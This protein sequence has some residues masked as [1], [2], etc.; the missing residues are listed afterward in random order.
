ML[1]T[2]T[3]K[4]ENHI[5][6]SYSCFDRV[7][8]RGYLCNIF[9]EGSV[10]NLLR[11]LGFRNHSNGVLKTLTNQL[12]SHIKKVSERMGV[13]IHWWGTSEKSKYQSKIDF[14]NDVYKRELHKKRHS[15]KVRTAGS[16]PRSNERQNIHCM[17]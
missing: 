5:N 16:V 10:I 2:I 13:V 14:V 17:L 1:N 4:L 8:F 7:V 6:F 3:D 12:N 9:V 15:I 11:N